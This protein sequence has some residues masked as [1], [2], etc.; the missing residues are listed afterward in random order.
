MQLNAI[1]DIESV[2]VGAT[3]VSAIV[4]AVAL[5][6]AYSALKL[7]ER[8]ATVEAF[9]RFRQLLI[10]HENSAALFLDGPPYEQMSQVQH[11][12]YTLIMQELFFAT[13]ALYLRTLMR[14]TRPD[15]WKGTK[16]ELSSSLR[17]ARCR[18]WWA[19]NA[20]LFDKSFREEIDSLI[21]S[22]V[23]VRDTK[24]CEHISAAS[25]APRC[26]T[27]CVHCSC[28]TCCKHCT[29]CQRCAPTFVVSTSSNEAAT[30]DSSAHNEDLE[31]RNQR[32]VE[33]VS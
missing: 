30:A 15:N 16:R 31:G 24:Y 13:Q 23:M 27:N 7:V 12:R 4:S 26:T 3:A 21:R 2:R 17:S 14:V 1:Y 8:K 18:L 25:A 6:M 33:G 28:C 20:A 9:S 11:L 32:E 5:V 10:T 22:E 19:D 29:C